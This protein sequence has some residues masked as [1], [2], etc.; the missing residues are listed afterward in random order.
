[1]RRAIQAI[2]IAVMAAGLLVDRSRR[3]RD[4]R[5]GEPSA[6]DR[7]SRP[8]LVLFWAGAVLLVL[9]SI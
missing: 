6:T 2:A 8:P 4:R 3:T 1:V 9:S 7:G 5:A